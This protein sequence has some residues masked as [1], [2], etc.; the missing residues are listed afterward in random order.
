MGGKSIDDY[1]AIRRLKEGEI[2][3]PFRSSDMMGNELVKVVK[4][5]KVIPSHNASLD[6]DYLRL[7]QM[8]LSAKQ[9]R[10]FKEWLNKKIA[11]MYIYIAP[12][13][14]SVEFENKNWVKYS[15]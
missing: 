8:A 7:E 10:E 3:E 14:R 6:E 11:A 12:E 5:L 4:L 2:S 15:K 13:F 1:N 9:E